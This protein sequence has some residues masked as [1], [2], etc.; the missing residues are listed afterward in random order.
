M[1]EPNSDDRETR[2]SW[3][4]SV[5]YYASG[6]HCKQLPGTGTVSTS[7]CTKL[8]SIACKLIEKVPL[9]SDPMKSKYLKS[10]FCFPK[11]FVILLFLDTFRI[12]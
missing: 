7:S 8:N 9:E 10:C 6:H 2:A 1:L 11:D 4:K 12:Q 5:T 3:D